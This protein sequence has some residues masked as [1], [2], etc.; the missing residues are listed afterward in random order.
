MIKNQHVEKVGVLTCPGPKGG[1][2]FFGK[3]VSLSSHG[4]LPADRE[5]FQVVRHQGAVRAHRLQHQRG[6]QGRAHR[7][8]RHREDLPA[9]DPRRQG[10]VRQ[11]REDPVPQGHPHRVPGAGVCLRPREEH[12]PADHGRF[13]RMD[14]T[15]GPGPS[16]GVR[17]PG[18]AAPDAVLPHGLGK[19]W[20]RTIC[21]STS[22]GCSGS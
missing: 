1:L 6:R 20:T 22:A 13:H 16:V 7:A 18:A 4:K 8:E 10:Q 9:T 12:L 19:A 17:A 3:C 21:G 11:R 2:I 5:Y 15:S 14:G